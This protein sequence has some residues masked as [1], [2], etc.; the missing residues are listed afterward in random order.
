MN[1]RLLPLT[2][3]SILVALAMVLELVKKLSFMQFLSL[4]NGGTIW[5]T[6]L[7]LII[8]GLRHGVFWGIL[9]GLVFSV[10][11]LMIDGFKIYGRGTIPFDYLLAYGVFGLSGLFN[12]KKKITFVL[13]F[14]FVGFLSLMMHTIA[15]IMDFNVSFPYSFLYNLTYIGPSTVISL[16][17]GYSIRP[18]I[19]K[20]FNS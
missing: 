18:A 6:M 3:T 14:L 20:D 4:P 7:P 19:L 17:I 2:E 12:A 11:N 5:I 9:G 10:V 15:G 1:R 8:I 13:A 16:I